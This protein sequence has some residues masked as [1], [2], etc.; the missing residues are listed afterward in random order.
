M[1]GQTLQQQRKIYGFSIC[2]HADY[3]DGAK[4]GE[5]FKNSCSKPEF[6]NDVRKALCVSMILTGMEI[7]A[8]RDAGLFIGEKR[9]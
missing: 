1:T 7:T 6:F 9:K 3:C 4:D 8:Q 5:S 2:P